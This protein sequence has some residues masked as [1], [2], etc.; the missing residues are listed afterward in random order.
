MFT[1]LLGTDWTANREYVLQQLAKDVQAQRP[2]CILMVPELISHETERRLCAVAGDT[3][4]RYAEVLSFTRLYRR[5]CDFTGLP[6]RAC[7]DNGGRLTAMASAVRQLHSKLKSYA[8]VETRPEFLIGLVEAVDEFK[9]CCISPEDLLAASRQANGLLAQKLEEL[10]LIYEAYNSL[11]AQGKRDPMDQMTWLLEQLEGSDFA[12]EHIFYIDGFP[13]FTRQHMEILKYLIANRGDVVVSLNCDAIGSTNPA[14]EKAGATASELYTAA[15]HAGVEIQVVSIA[16]RKDLLQK[17]RG[18]LFS[19]SAERDKMLDSVLRLWHSESVYEECLAAAGE[20]LSLVQSGARYRDI[21]VVCADMPGYQSTLRMVFDRCKIPIYQSGKDDI[22]EK[23]IIATVL[24]AV[25]AS[26]NG[27]DT[28]DM[29]RYLRSMLSPLDIASCDRLENYVLLW[30]IRGT[31]W[32]E[33]WAYHPQGLN[34]E[35]S[36]TDRS[37]LD[38]LNRDRELVMEPLLFLRQGFQNAINIQQQ[39]Q[40]LY[41]FLEKIHL[42]KRLQQVAKQMEAA[43]DHRN[44]QMLS[45]LWEILLAALEQLYDTLGQT[46]WDSENFTHLLQLLLSQYDVGS[47]PPVLDSV[48]V[49]PVSAMRCQ[50]TKHLFVLG[51]LEGN[52][53]GYSGSMGVLTD[54]ERTFLRQLGIPLTGGGMDGIQAEFAE[55]Y[56]VFCGAMETVNVSCPGGQPSFI[57]RRLLKI[58]GGETAVDTR[59]GA[60]RSDKL[61]AAAFLARWNESDTAESLGVMKEYAQVCATQNHSLGTLNPDNIRE[62]YGEQLNLSASQVDRQAECRLMYFLRYGLRAKERKPAAVDPSEFGTYVHDVLENTV[63]EVMERGGFHAVSWEDTR[64]IALKFS[65]QYV[66]NCF[67][68]LDSQRLQYLLGRNEQELLMVVQELWDELRVSD[69]EPAYCELGFGFGGELEAIPIG[70]HLL[71]AVL[72]GRVDRVDSWNK[73]GYSYYRVVDYKTGKKD[74]D[75]CDIFNGYG[76]QMLLYLF[77]LED[78][79]SSVIGDRAI[80]AGVQYF[81]ARSPLLTAD[82]RLSDEEAGNMRV[83]EWKR[84]G[85]ILAQEDILKA[86]DPAEKSPRFS[87]SINKAG[88]LTGD[89]ADRPSFRMLRKYIFA[90]LQKLVDEIS[91]GEVAPNPYTRGS[92]HNACAFCPFGAVCYPSQVEGRR[93]YK[94]MT[95]QRFWE[96]VEREVSKNG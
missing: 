5:V 17:V 72:G 86:M 70:G 90:Y 40:I 37:A 3:A 63:R 51:A 23:P 58:A 88:E 26:L 96:E 31:R 85:L 19:G 18:S 8:S 50:Q 11:C 81:P 42:A 69:F 15:I 24:S 73:D 14:F 76:L 59:L 75:Y 43:G 67:S 46:S 80:P 32:T 12:Q 33:T 95:A 62:L 47:I 35:W 71:P 45:Q 4:S 6:V 49:G 74:F 36:D 84:K 41:E 89:I 9:R 65:K 2:N 92:S 29:L 25:D 20:I 87:C 21:S 38:G 1:L 39:V 54:Q 30:G 55:I 93:N 22:L 68:Q 44:G 56:G 64:D 82:G 7:L 60:A 53:P 83:K 27:F 10:S 57:Y 34:Q 66:Q 94:T 28:R 79:D 91:S 52:L 16:P 48:V 13:D 77:A 78:A 61:E